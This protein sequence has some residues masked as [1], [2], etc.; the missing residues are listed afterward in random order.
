LKM[1]LASCT[2]KLADILADH[3]PLVAGFEGRSNP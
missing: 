1:P 2:I 3:Y